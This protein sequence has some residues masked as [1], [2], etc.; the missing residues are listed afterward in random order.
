M[1]VGVGP[2][3]SRG[4]QANGARYKRNACFVHG[5][6]GYCAE[7]AFQ[8]KTIVSYVAVLMWWGLNKVVAACFNFL[9]CPIPKKK[10][11]AACTLHDVV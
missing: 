10:K 2:L 7:F 9:E 11:K 4:H 5:K 6:L 3:H 8:Y 1:C